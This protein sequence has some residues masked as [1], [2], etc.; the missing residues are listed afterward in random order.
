MAQ[1]LR[2]APV[3][4]TLLGHIATAP[5]LGKHPITNIYWDPTLNKMVGEYDNAGVSAGTIMS[6]PPTGKFTVT[7]IF[8]DPVTGKMIGEYDSGD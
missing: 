4:N 7:N 1:L 8:F 2:L 6:N 5:P 3:S